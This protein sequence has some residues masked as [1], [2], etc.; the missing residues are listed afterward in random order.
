MREYYEDNNISN[1]LS[2]HQQQQDI[3]EP[4]QPNGL[5]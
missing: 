3:E 1:S 2:N 5:G 4:K